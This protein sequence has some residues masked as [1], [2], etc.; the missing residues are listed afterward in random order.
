MTPRRLPTRLTALVIGLVLYGFSISLMN[1]AAVGISPWDVLSQGVSLQTGIPFGM[2][3]NLIGAAVLLLWW[4]LKQKPGIGTVLNVLLI[5]T[6]AQAGL[7]LLPPVESLWIRIPMF[8]AGLLLLAVASG[9]YIAPRLGPGPRDGLMTGL[10]QRF[11]WP[12]WIARTSIEVCVALIGFALG[13]NLGVGTVVFA[14]LIGPL[15]QRTLPWFAARIPGGR[16]P[17]ASREA[18]ASGERATSGAHA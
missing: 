1:R 3:T 17:S 2:V 16:A 4:P 14:L 13:G 15:C 10:N 9:L 5:G 6:S 11:G 12:I 7:W 18:G 8:A